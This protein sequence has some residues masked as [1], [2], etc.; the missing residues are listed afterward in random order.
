MIP[1]RVT[2]P[3][4]PGSSENAPDV[5]NKAGG[6]GNSAQDISHAPAKSE[7]L[8]PMGKNRIEEHDERMNDF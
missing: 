7:E 8:I 3:E 6:N 2:K 4:S 5:D 1:T